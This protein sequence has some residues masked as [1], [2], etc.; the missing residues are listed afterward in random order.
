MNA[1]KT[2]QSLIYFADG[3]LQSLLLPYGTLIIMES[4]NVKVS[5]MTIFDSEDTI[6]RN[7]KANVIIS[8]CL[9][10]SFY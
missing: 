4:L 10:Q 2:I 7:I 3:I 6:N 8:F 9:Y 5:D 1:Y